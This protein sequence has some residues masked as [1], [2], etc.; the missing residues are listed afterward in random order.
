MKKH[1]PKN[2]DNISPKFLNENTIMEIEKD[3]VKFENLEKIKDLG[4]GTYGKVC[5]YK[6]RNNA[7]KLY[8]VKFFFE[9]PSI[10]IKAERNYNKEVHNN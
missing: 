5:L 9:V 10:K 6:A 4:S 2:R 3:E 8:A 7:Q 1:M